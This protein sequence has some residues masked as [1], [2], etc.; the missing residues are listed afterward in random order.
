M[1]IV[2]LISGKGTNL[3]DILMQLGQL[4]EKKQKHPLASVVAIGSDTP[5]ANLQFFTSCG[6]DTFCVDF[7]KYKSRKEWDERMIDAV[8]AYSPDLVVLSGFMRILSSDFINFFNG[9]IINTHPSFLPSFPGHR[10]VKDALEA[11]V[12]ET[13]ASVIAIDSGVDTGRILTQEKIKILPK[14]TEETLHHRIKL[15]E[16]RLLFDV[17]KAIAFGNI[18]I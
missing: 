11:G 5:K 12:D 16:R 14:D 3:R 15:V 8:A 17:I 10:A 6:I 4:G 13:G 9:K 7:S 1:K 2:A 18:N